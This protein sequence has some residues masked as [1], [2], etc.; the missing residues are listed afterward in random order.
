MK[1]KGITVDIDMIEAAVKEM[2]DAAEER[3]L[4][5]FDSIEIE[6][7]A[8]ADETAKQEEPITT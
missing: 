1:A 2:N 3:L 4:S 5:I 8:D 6:D 7:D